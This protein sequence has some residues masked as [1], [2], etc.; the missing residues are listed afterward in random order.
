V[1]K[2]YEEKTGPRVP[3]E[4]AQQVKW[5]QTSEQSDKGAFL[6]AIVYLAFAGLNTLAFA[7]LHFRHYICKAAQSR[8]YLH[9]P[10]RFPP[11]CLNLNSDL[12]L[13]SS[14]AALSCRACLPI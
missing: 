10:L 8:W 1:N 13:I 3:R 6:W 12:D 5:T 7:T 9:L 11:L 2:E 4:T 14:L